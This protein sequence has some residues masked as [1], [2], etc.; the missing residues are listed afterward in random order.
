MP[1]RA[2]A[3]YIGYIAVFTEIH[4][5]LSQPKYIISPACPELVGHTQ[6]RG[7]WEAS[8]SDANVTSAAAFQ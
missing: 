6:K 4:C 2:L 5:N 1:V 3:T 7:I 8:W